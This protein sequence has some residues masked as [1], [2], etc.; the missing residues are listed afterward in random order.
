MRW[1]PVP[2]IIRRPSVG[3]V[4]MVAVEW[5]ASKPPEQ[6]FLMCWG[7]VVRVSTGGS[8]RG[9]RV[10]MTILRMSFET[11]ASPVEMASLVC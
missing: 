4:L 7:R 5:P 10:A 2:P 6:L 9:V 8:N 1:E 3:S 11:V